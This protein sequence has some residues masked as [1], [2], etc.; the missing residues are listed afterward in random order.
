ML[1]NCLCFNHILRVLTNYSV[2]E[3]VARCD[4]MLDFSGDASCV[5]YSF[6]LLIPMGPPVA[7]T[8]H[9]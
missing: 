3:C 1:L 7:T 2:P 9:F 4:P 5:L 8:D 6:V